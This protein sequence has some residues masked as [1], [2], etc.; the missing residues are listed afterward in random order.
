[1]AKRIFEDEPIE[2]RS[3]FEIPFT[4]IPNALWEMKLDPFEYA[5]ICR[6]IMRAGALHEHSFESVPDMAAACSMSVR[7]FENALNTLQKQ[8]IIRRSAEFDATGTQTFSTITVND[9][10]VWRVCE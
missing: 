9:I 4:M 6:I 8:N 5:A 1:M 10:P 7:L 2:F 3:Q